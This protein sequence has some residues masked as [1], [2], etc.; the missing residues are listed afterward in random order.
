VPP[1]EPDIGVRT[2]AIPDRAKE[3]DPDAVP[4]HG[5]V[6]ARV[7]VGDLHFYG[8]PSESLA[9]GTPLCRSA[10]SPAGVPP[11]VRAKDLIAE[12]DSI[13][14]Q[15]NRIMSQVDRAVAKLTTSG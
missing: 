9:R 6:G 5:T 11:Q 12:I 15:I 3:R 13:N 10:P 8:A 1:D 2:S 4:V 14:A 7:S